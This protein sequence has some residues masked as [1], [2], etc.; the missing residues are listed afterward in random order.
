MRPSVA[1]YDTD[2]D[3]MFMT[4][5][6]RPDRYGFDFSRNLTT[7]FEIHGE[8]AWVRNTRKTVLNTAGASEVIEG[9]RTAF[10]SVCGI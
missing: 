3:V 10:L 7:N 9:R 6:S 1:F 8:Y 4:G 2:I 5:P